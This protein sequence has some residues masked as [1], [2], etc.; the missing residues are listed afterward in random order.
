MVTDG[1]AGVG[2]TPVTGRPRV[3]SQRTLAAP[4]GH[5]V[6]ASMWWRLLRLPLGLAT[7]CVHA[8]LQRLV[9]APPPAC[10][11]QRLVCMCLSVSGEASRAP[12]ETTAQAEV[13]SPPGVQSHGGQEPKQIKSVPSAER[14]LEMDPVATRGPRGDP[15]PRGAQRGPAQRGPA[16]PHRG[17]RGL[18]SCPATQ[19]DEEERG[20]GGEGAGARTPGPG[21]EGAAC[22]GPAVCA[23]SRRPTVN[24]TL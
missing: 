8:F 3:S 24:W 21:R 19:R 7:D 20:A 5:C 2:S 22:G 4:L 17:I 6:A 11:P 23:Q 14:W 9:L 15:E 12:G 10:A 16:Q 18:P 13:G 1:P